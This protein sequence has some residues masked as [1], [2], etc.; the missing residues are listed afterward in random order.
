MGREFCPFMNTYVR[1]GTTGLSQDPSA[2]RFNVIKFQPDRIGKVFP[3]FHHFFIAL[4]IEPVDF[5]ADA[6]AGQVA[7]MAQHLYDELGRGRI[8]IGKVKDQ[9]QFLEFVSV[10]RPEYGFHKSLQPQERFLIKTRNVFR[11]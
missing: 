7:Y 11:A 5:Y 9:M 6:V 10:A 3:V 2:F 8:K 4:L 1:M